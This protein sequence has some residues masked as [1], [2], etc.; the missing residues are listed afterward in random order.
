[1]ELPL[2]KHGPFC[3]CENCPSRAQPKDS[4]PAHSF[5]RRVRRLWKCA[6]GRTCLRAASSARRAGWTSSWASWRTA[7]GV[8]GDVGLEGKFRESSATIRR[9]IMFAASLYI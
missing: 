2:G 1:M 6:R 7:A 9:D 4:E 5:V 8:V 3:G